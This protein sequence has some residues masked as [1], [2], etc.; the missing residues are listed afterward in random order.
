MSANIHLAP[1]VVM[2]PAFALPKAERRADSS[3]I[4]DQLLA[5]LTLD[6]WHAKELRKVLGLSAHAALGL[7]VRS[8]PSQVS[9]LI[10]CSELRAKFGDAP[11]RVAGF[12]VED[13]EPA[14][15]DPLDDF[16][17][18]ARDALRLN[19]PAHGLV[20]RVC[21]GVTRGLQLY[22]HAKD[23]RPRW[24][25]SAE[26]PGDVRAKAS[27]HVQGSRVGNATGKA[28][29]VSHTLEAMAVALA[30]GQCA[31]A[32]NGVSLRA[33]PAQLFEVLPNLRGVMVAM[34]DAPPRLAEELKSAGLAVTFWEGGDLL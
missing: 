24:L 5:W 10:V 6:K 33:L 15:D 3:A 34:K 4:L 8:C 25:T 29:L 16:G 18:T 27:I 32:L 23:E 11:E 30:H 13:V 31:V 14:G 7:G 12:Y 20:V 9:K 19:T 22:R 28:F 1:P 21:R 17:E 2:P 26:L